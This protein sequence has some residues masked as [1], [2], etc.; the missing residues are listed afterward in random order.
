MERAATAPGTVR[1]PG[2]PGINTS[3]KFAFDAY[4][5]EEFMHLTPEQI[6]HR[7]MT[8]GV[9]GCRKRD[10]RQAIRALNALI[11]SLD[12]KYEEVAM[13]LF[14]L[15]DYCKS[16]VYSGKFGEAIKVLDELRMTWAQAF[17]L[18]EAA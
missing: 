10:R 11:I 16:C 15:Y 5:R 8:L 17:H 14:R 3:Q 18:R 12:F 9:Q 13:G 1:A 2:S 6:I 7:L 4:R